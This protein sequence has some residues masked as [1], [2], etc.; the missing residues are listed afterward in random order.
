[1]TETDRPLVLARIGEITL[2]G[3]NRYKFEDRLMLNMRYRL[4]HMGKVWIRKDQ[5]RF[6]AEVPEG[7]TSDAVIEGL[8]DVFGIVSLSPVFVADGDA[9]D[10]LAAAD[11]VFDLL[12]E[13]GKSRSFKVETRRVD[14]AFPLRSYDISATVGQRLMERFSGRLTVDV[15]QPDVTL[16][17]E[18]RDRFY[19]YHEVVP[20]PRG[21]PVGMSGSGMLLLSGGIDSPVA[22]YKMASRGMMLESIYFHTYP[23]TGDEVLE[24]VRALGRILTRFS[25]HMDLHVVDFTKI[26]LDIQS[27]CPEDMITIVMRRMMMRIAERLAESRRCKSLITGESLGQVASQT[28]EALVTTD[29]VV[30]MPV[31]RPLIGNDKDETVGIARLIGTFETSV[32]PYADCCTVFVSKHPKTHPSLK[33]AHDAESR[34]DIEELVQ[35]G[36]EHITSERLQ[37][38]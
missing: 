1:M 17:L 29:E 34:L 8:K 30:R 7:W 21:L 15:H 33:A 32:L 4:R 38:S 24:K 20:G 5:S 25:G 26:Q 3:L 6:L 35:Y 11:D 37:F 18:I 28:Q 12:M 14:K 27:L 22:G 10:L 2:K 19:L 23:Y 31:F 9:N 16:H 36:L 13:D